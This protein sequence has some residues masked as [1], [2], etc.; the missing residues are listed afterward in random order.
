MRKIYIL[1]LGPS[2]YLLFLCPSTKGLVK[3]FG[4]LIFRDYTRNRVYL[5]DKS[6][7]S[8]LQSLLVGSNYIKSKKYLF[9][10]LQKCPKIV[11]KATE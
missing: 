1:T 8:Y 11:K 6:K 2:Q 10:T 4:R 9:C 7:S 5:Q 3:V